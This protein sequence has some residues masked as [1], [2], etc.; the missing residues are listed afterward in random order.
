MLTITGWS[1]GAAAQDT[2]LLVTYGA[3]A[4]T[5]EGDPDFHQSV[6][7]SLPADFQDRLYLRLFDADSGGAHDLEGRGPS[8]FRYA[9]YG[10]EAAAAALTAPVGEDGLS[11]APAG[12]GRLLYEEIVGEDAASDDRWRTV[13]V[14]NPVDGALVDGRRIFRFDAVGLDGNAGNVYDVRLSLRDRRNLAPEGV[15]TFSLMP[16][17]RVLN[18]ART[19]ELR[20]RVPED[21][22]ALTVANFDTAHARLVMRTAFSDVPLTASGQDE[23][24]RD[25]VM[26]DRPL[27]TDLAGITITGGTETP[28]DVT[29]LI[30]DHNAVP[31]P[32]DLPPRDLVLNQ[33]P[34]P[35]VDIASLA[36]CVAFVFD[37]SASTDQ[38]GDRLSY[39][40][41]FDD[42]T[43]KTGKSVLQEFATS[44]HHNG[45]LLLTDSSGQIG[46]GASLTFS[47]FSKP[48]PT[49]VIASPAMV[50]VG[51]EVTLDATA[52]EAGDWRLQRFEWLFND[53]VVM[54]GPKVMRTFQQPGSYLVTLRATDDSGHACETGTAQ[55]T[56]RVNAPPVAVAG[57]DQKLHLGDEL[58]VDG[59]A[60]YDRD[61]RIV[62]HRWAL[63]DGTLSDGPVARH[64]FKDPGTYVVTLTVTDDS[65]APNGVDEDTMR[66]VV[67]APPVAAAG[68]DRS[69]AVGE[70]IAFDGTGSHDPDGMISRFAWAF[71]DGSVAA[72]PVSDYAFAKSGTYDVS[73][74]VSD[75]S[76]FAQSQSVDTVR[77]TVNDPPVAE[78]GPDQS[79]TRS[80]VQFDGRASSDADGAI[81]RYDWDFGDGERGIGSAPAHV[82]RRPGRYP[83]RLTVTD[84]SDTIRNTAEDTMVVLV[85]AA[86]IADA[87]RN[88]IAAPNET[89]TIQG[90]RS[91]DPDGDIVAHEWTLG[92]GATATGPILTHTYGAPGTYLVTLT[93][94]DDSGHPEAFDIDEAEIV[95]NAAPTAVAG[96]DLRVAPGDPV[97]FDAGGSFDTDGAIALTRWDFSD[98]ADPD[99]APRV[100]RD[101]GAP[102]TYTAHLTVTDDSGALNG[103]AEDDM[104]ILVN[105]RPAASAG[106]DIVQASTTVAF[107]AGA[108]VDPDGD[109]LTYTWSFGDGASGS[110]A[111]AVHTFAEGGTYPVLLTVDDGTGLSNAADTDE[112][113]VTI[114]RAPIAVAGENRRVCTDDVIAFDGSASLD[115]DGGVLSHAWDF[116]DGTASDVVNPTKAYREGGT[117]AVILTVR[118]ESGLANSGGTNRIAVEVDQGPIARAGPDISACVNTEVHFDGSNSWDID[119]VVNSYG[120][121]FGDGGQS[122]G[123][124]PFHIYTRPGTYRAQLTI[125]GEVVG[126]CDRVASD[127]ILV[128]ILEGPHPVIDA[129]AAVAVAE[130]AVFD[131]RASTM[132]DG[133][134]LDYRWDFGD[135]STAT[136][137]TVRH[138]FQAPGDHRV[139]LTLVTNSPH[140]TCQSVSAT[141]VVTANAAPVADAGPDRE[142]GVLESVTFDGT[143]SA[144]A[145]GGILTYAWDFGDGTKGERSTVRH[146]YANPGTYIVRL[147][148]TD[149]AG[150]SN[151]TVVDTARVVVAPAPAVAIAAPS[152]SCV[153]EAVEMT[154]DGLSG[155]SAAARWR[156]GDGTEAEGTAVR[157][158]YERPGRYEVVAMVDN[159]LGH[160]NS[161]RQT[162]HALQID[163]PPQAFAGPDRTVC[164]GEPVTFDATRSGDIDDPAI[165]FRWEFGD[166]ASGGGPVTQHTF[167]TPGRY[168][169]RLTAT[170]PAGASCSAATDDAFIT[171][172][173]PPIADAGPDRDGFTGGAHDGILLDASGSRDPDGP[174]LRYTWT[175][176][177]EGVTLS[178]QR[179]RHQFIQPGEVAVGLTVSDH[180]GL[181]CGVAH[182]E[183]L[184]RIRAHDAPSAPPDA[185]ATVAAR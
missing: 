128:T 118:D 54:E 116:G 108:S 138:T 26:I 1:V 82:Y 113:T 46:D 153:G 44:G 164:P 184:V 68:S 52:S 69:A 15:R 96:P 55:A 84:D 135:G 112:M 98:R 173:A 35:S 133:A 156:F 8:R 4:P 97:V 95:V 131:A 93:V 33:R 7:F 185:P 89:V 137:E 155:E 161:A 23:W 134:I 140:P 32:I 59:S 60:S 81:I 90:D 94:R 111:R 101:F 150:V 168:R 120:W 74:T 176:P 48:R 47:V 78:A 143:G 83:V 2:P 65:G 38:D 34:T 86:P 72:G 20:F 181:Q 119:G 121:D 61:G 6:Y 91:I 129:P 154:L 130:E 41:E 110:G 28:N 182:D 40:W 125:V 39:A 51:E 50:A 16:T 132:T 105:A 67:N 12:T 124:R 87:G 3:G 31:V 157:H 63:G 36:N 22:A 152:A 166:G 136:G 102:G 18:S 53:G 45:R 66:V 75:D 180:T 178:G 160:D 43:R 141:K 162:T 147:A 88:Q 49:A 37:A 167:A 24:E 103:Q 122:G 56:L 14:V 169:V 64:T 25:I 171:V 10:G 77:I 80:L 179:V 100:E 123:E 146:R 142:V 163:R 9:L 139:S 107:D 104:T 92:D 114:N 99:Y 177:S 106:A 159:G 70:V 172:N 58:V 158:L 71:A 13:A 27:A 42:G 109:A 165:A 175:I 115:P 174:S 145:D 79:L 57:R 126:Q 11:E 21:A 76:G 73:L 149:N 62:S 30:T 183:V 85:N 170:D 127:E 5:R 19:T 117:Y 151:S 29:L 148:I 144:D 17:V